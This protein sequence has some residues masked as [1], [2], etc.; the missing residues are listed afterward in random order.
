MNGNLKV[1]DYRISDTGGGGGGGNAGGASTSFVRLNSCRKLKFWME[2]LKRE[3][4]VSL[5]LEL[6]RTISFRV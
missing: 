4:S 1:V 2:G 6:F 3:G 5:F